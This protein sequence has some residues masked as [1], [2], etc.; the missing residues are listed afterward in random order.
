MKKLFDFIGDDIEAEVIPNK[1]MRDSRVDEEDE[2]LDMMM[3]WIMI[4][5][6]CVVFSIWTYVF[7]ALHFYDIFCCLFKKIFCFTHM[8]PDTCFVFVL[9]L[10]S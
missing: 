3:I 10:E 6:F 8:D 9:S 5:S 4:C 1:T 2:E 7:Y